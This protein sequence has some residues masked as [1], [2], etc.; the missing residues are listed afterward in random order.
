MKLVHSTPFL[1][2]SPKVAKHYLG[3]GMSPE[4]C[5]RLEEEEDNVEEAKH[6]CLLLESFTCMTL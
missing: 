5:P 2:Q 4:R 6:Q 1:H 3:A